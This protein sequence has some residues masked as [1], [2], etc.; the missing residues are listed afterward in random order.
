MI[1]SRLGSGGLLAVGAC[2]L[3]LASVAIA[4]TTAATSTTE[5]DSQAVE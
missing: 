2:S 1:M 3:M 4:D 5:P